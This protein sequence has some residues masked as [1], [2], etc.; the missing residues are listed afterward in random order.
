MLVP[1]RQER[2]GCTTLG[3]RACVKDFA[4]KLGEKLIV[5]VVVLNR[6]AR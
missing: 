1:S 5:K 4:A 6:I 2:R 3:K